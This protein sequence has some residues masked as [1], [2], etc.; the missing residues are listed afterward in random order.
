MPALAHLP[1]A[2]A[3]LGSSRAPATAPPRASPCQAAEQMPWPPANLTHCFWLVS[4]FGL[5]ASL[6]IACP[7]KHLSS[8]PHLRRGHSCLRILSRH[9]PSS[10]GLWFGWQFGGTGSPANLNWARERHAPAASTSSLLRALPAPL[11]KPF[12]RRTLR[13]EPMCYLRTAAPAFNCLGSHPSLPRAHHTPAFTP[14]DAH[15]R[16]CL[17]LDQMVR[18]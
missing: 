15:Q 14:A 11:S 9:T 3:S 1:A 8:T 17:D 2:S 5:S 7:A 4:Q 10:S 13:S 16:L 6:H 12:A 18:Y